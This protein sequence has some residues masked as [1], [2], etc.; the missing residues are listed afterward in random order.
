MCSARKLECKFV[1][2]YDL[3]TL[4]G[5]PGISIKIV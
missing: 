2:I 1:R 3:I 4:I 5:C